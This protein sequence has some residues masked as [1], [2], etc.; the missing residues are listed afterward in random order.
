MHRPTI[1]A[2]LQPG[3]LSDLSDRSEPSGRARTDGPIFE[4]HSGPYATKKWADRDRSSRWRSNQPQI[5]QAASPARRQARCPNA[6]KTPSPPA[7]RM[8]RSLLMMMVAS[9]PASGTMGRR[10]VVT[11]KAQGFHGLL[12]PLSH[13]AVDCGCR[14]DYFFHV[15][16]AVGTPWRGFVHGVSGFCVRLANLAAVIIR[17]HDMTPMHSSCTRLG[18]PAHARRTR[19][20]PHLSGDPTTSR[21]GQFF[22]RPFNQPS[23]AAAWL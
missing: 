12:S 17:W 9:A 20:A 7:A 13:M 14:Q 16:A 22:L 21:L 23:A 5:R 19:A 4:A 3:S 15:P 1:L 2:A 11:W 8:R 18:H 6:R 10:S